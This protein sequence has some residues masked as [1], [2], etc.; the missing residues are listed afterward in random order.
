VDPF[1]GVALRD[2]DGDMIPTPAGAGLTKA[3]FSGA[4]LGLALKDLP[5]WGPHL[6]RQPLY[7]RYPADCVL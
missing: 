7:A 6:P 2:D 1:L 5:L 3:L 4:A